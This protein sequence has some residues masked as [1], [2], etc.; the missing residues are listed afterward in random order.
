MNFISF[1]CRGGTLP[2]A[3]GNASNEFFV[4]RGGG[5]NRLAAAGRIFSA[6][7]ASAS[8]DGIARLVESRLPFCAV[9][10]S[11]ALWKRFR[12]IDDT[13]AKKQ[14][15]PIEPNKYQGRHA[16]NVKRFLSE[17]VC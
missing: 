12:S 15:R 5:W 8:S 3:C 13:L 7:L 2:R 6:R 1:T 9:N 14:I 16:E 4:D 11:F 17:R 10:D